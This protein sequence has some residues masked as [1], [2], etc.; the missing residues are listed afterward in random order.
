MISEKKIQ[1]KVYIKFIILIGIL[2]SFYYSNNY[3][4]SNKKK[5]VKKERMFRNEVA[6]YTNKITSFNNKTED[7][8]KALKTWEDLIS[9][10]DEGFTGLKISTAKDIVN[11]LREKYNFYSL[12]IQMSKPE[13]IEDKDKMSD[14]ISSE[15]SRMQII[16]RGLTDI[17]MLSFI[18]DLKVRFPGYLEFQ[19]YSVNLDRDLDS[20]FLAE[21]NKSEGNYSAVTAEIICNWYDLRE[22]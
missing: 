16:I 3:L 19:S 20:S 18:N 17:D 8:E 6:T 15:F 14:D 21:Y 13:I 2:G 7:I 10:R 1:I 5:L 12:N 4:T 11:D 22:K 9:E